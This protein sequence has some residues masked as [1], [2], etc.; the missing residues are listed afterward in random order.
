M[1]D[2]KAAEQKQKQSLEPLTY[3]AEWAAGQD[4]KSTGS[5]SAKNKLDMLMERL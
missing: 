1:Q 4:K 3:L 5:T 2:F